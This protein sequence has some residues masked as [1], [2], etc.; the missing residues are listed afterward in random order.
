M[1]LMTRAQVLVSRLLDALLRRRRDSRLS[2]EIT[3]HLELLTD[4]YVARGLTPNAARAAARRAFGGVDQLK[5]VYRDQR[6]LPIVDALAQDLQFAW[7]LLRRDRGF[8]VT[9][10]LVLGLGIGVNNMLF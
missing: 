6:G 1:T 5:A 4:D 10:V 8:S 3:T 2:E 7:R 9:A